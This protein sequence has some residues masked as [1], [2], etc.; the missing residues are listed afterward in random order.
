[1]TA[2]VRAELRK[3]ATT[4][5]WLVL[6]ACAVGLMLANLA[7]SAVFAAWHGPG[8]PGAP[9][10]GTPQ[11][12]RSLL[13]SVTGGTVAATLLGVLS[14]TTEYRHGTITWAFLACPRR[15]DLVTA[16]LGAGL[17]AGA[18][19]G[20]AVG[21]LCVGGAEVALLVGARPVWPLAHGGGAILAGGVLS[22]A[23]HAVVGA[24]VGWLI[25]NQVAAVL[26]VL[27]WTQAVEGTLVAL[28]PGLGRWLLSGAGSA[29]TRYG[30]TT[31]LPLLPAWAGALL[32]LGYGAAFALLG[33]AASR[34]ELRC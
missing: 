9:G 11:G 10:L 26:A 29:L 31:G 34:R 15:A 16:K 17:L 6:L 8:A 21:L 1:M 13:A 4:R 7:I 18:A 28:L 2:L 32:L 23:L 24:G 25:R 20:V 19:L 14:V 5:A 27:V 33:Y 22:Y 30:E 12:V 3:L